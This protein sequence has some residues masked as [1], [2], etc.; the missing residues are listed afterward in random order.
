MVLIKEN[1]LDGGCYFID[2]VVIL[3]VGFFKYLYFVGEID[4]FGIFVK[5]IVKSE[6]KLKE[7]FESIFEEYEDGEMVYNFFGIYIEMESRIFLS[8]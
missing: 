4:I 1:I 7:I 2:E 5:I 8:L 6:K 3:V